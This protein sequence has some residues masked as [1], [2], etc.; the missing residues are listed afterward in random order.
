M[1]INDPEIV[2]SELLRRINAI[3]ER[4]HPTGPELAALVAEALERQCV[5][6]MV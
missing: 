4:G 1:D 5:S 3:K 6:D 2:W